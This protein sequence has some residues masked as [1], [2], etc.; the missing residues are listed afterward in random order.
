M[1]A[2]FLLVMTAC[3]V[4]A[5]PAQAPPPAAKP[6]APAAIVAPAAAGCNDCGG[7]G[8]EKEG[9]LAKLKSKFHHNDCGCAPAPAPACNTCD[10]CGHEGLLSKF[11]GKFH[12]NDCGCAPAN[13][14]GCGHEGFLSKLK[15]KFHHNDCC[16]TCNTCGSAAPAPIK[17][18]TIPAPKDA[19]PKK[20]PE[21]KQ[22]FNAPQ[23]LT[24]TL[25]IEKTPF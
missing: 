18:E 19:G 14:C 4:G 20:M 11:K 22:A 15:G 8:C 21:G 7:C 2:A 10:T 17:G 25:V 9:F 5:D 1:N 3:S 16:D 12:H 6:A 24:G 13:D 23:P